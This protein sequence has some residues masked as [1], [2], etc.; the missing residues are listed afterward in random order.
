MNYFEATNLV[1]LLREL[2][3]SLDD[4]INNPAVPSMFRQQ[5]RET[6][7]AEDTVIFRPARFLV[8]S[9][10]RD[11]WLIRTDRQNWYY[12]P[13]LRGYLLA[14]KGWNSAS[15]RS[16][17]ETTDRILELLA[18]P[19]REQ[20][21]I[22]GL[23]VG[24]VQS[25]KT[26]N[27]TALIA[28]AADVGYRLVIVL[29]GID[30]GLRMQTQTRLNK[31]L[32]G[33]T[34]NHPGSVQLPPVGKRWHQFTTEDLNGDFRPGNANHAALQ[35]DQPVLLVIKKNGAVLR[36]LRTWIEAAPEDVRRNLPVLVIDDESDQ[37]SIDTRGSYLEENEPIPDDYEEPSVINRLIRDLLR[38]FQRI[39]YV[40]YTATPF[41]NILIPHDNYD[42]Y[43]EDDLYPRDFI[44]DLPKPDGYFGSEELF[45]RLDMATGE[46]IEGLNVIRSVPET[47]FNELGNKILPASLENAIIDFVLAGA[48]KAQRDMGN[49]PATM[50]IHGS[51][52]VLRQNEIYQMVSE[53][54]S[55]LKD[56]WRYQRNQGILSRLRDRWENEFRPVIREYHLDKDVDFDLIEPFV[57]PFFESVQVKVI[58]S[59]SGAILDYE[60]EPGLK[61]IAVGGNRLSRGL[62]LEGLQIS[63]FLRPTT[64]YD[65]LMQMGRWFGFRRGYEDLTRIYMT[66]DLAGWF[67]ILSMVE[68]ELRQDIRRYEAQNVTPLQLATRI[69][70]HPS[71][72]VTSRLKQRYAQRITVQQSYSNQVL[73]TIRFPFENLTELNDLLNSNISTTQT[74]LSQLGLPDQMDGQNPTWLNISSDQVLQYLQNYSVY[75]EART[76]AMPLIINYIQHQNDVDELTNWTIA[77]KGRTV[78]DLRL[79][80]IDL[81]I[82][83]RVP[84]IART[85]LKSDPLSLGVITSPGDETAGL[86]AEQNERVQQ[87]VEFSGREIGIN[88]AAREERSPQNGLLLIYPVSRYSGYSLPLVGSQTRKRIYINP[89]DP[90]ARD[91]ICLAISFPKSD[92]AVSVSGV[93][94]VGTVGW[95][96][97]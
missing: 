72:L 23:V 56:E 62:T 35:G 69:R 52:L 90:L 20:F 37:A 71:M 15:V 45:G 65:T 46:Q 11:E 10:A 43:V 77:V 2:G 83:Q 17:D 88:P 47:D 24:F 40:A 59:A 55:E 96:S 76:L 4:A 94:V 8:N 97:Q 86:T 95:V 30:N 82:G 74:F 67:T 38:R 12:W 61:A 66:D 19:K 80:D 16:L 60:H 14:I 75:T 22:K 68:Y 3:N 9:P 57:G 93:Y 28:K 1:R 5:L 33:Y 36:R 7:E 27:Y 6:F 26:A 44:V 31:E 53:K 89:E 58:N 84:L 25:G 51:R 49:T 32:V 13:T 70:Y 21:D 39:S 78:L 91:I 41:A 50:L 81:G 29:S 42:P 64:M 48:G 87:R 92:N 79:G 18:P 54:F 85:R 34:E 73:Q 63:Y